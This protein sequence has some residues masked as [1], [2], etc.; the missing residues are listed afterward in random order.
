MIQ[1]DDI[2]IP[3]QNGL[4]RYLGIEVIQAEGLGK[5]PEYPFVTM[6]KITNAIPIGQSVSKMNLEEKMIL[7]QDIEMVFS[8]T[9]NANT[10]ENADDY[11]MKAR[12]YVEGLGYYELQ[13]H[14][15][16][17]VDVLPS[18]NRDV[19]MTVDYERR[20]G[21]DVRLRVRGRDTYAIEAIEKAN[22]RRG[23]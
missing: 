18:T 1:Y 17:V 19:F 6:K 9:V 11:A 13:D 22:L 2:W 15:I 7:E 23:N 4:S 12:S 5:K 10:I 3:L 16:T 8:L 21:F 20:V 14:N